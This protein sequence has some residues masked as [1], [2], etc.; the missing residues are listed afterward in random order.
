MATKEEKIEKA[1]TILSFIILIFLLV[2]II[3]GIVAVI[4]SFI[5]LGY[6]LTSLNPHV[7]GCRVYGPAAIGFPAGAYTPFCDGLS[8]VNPLPYSG[9]PIII[10]DAGTPFE[11][12]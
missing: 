4:A 3:G 7:P 12:Q 9:I 11:S 6:L 1:D 2:W 8:K 10:F 5:C